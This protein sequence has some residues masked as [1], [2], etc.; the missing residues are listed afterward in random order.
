M[1]PYYVESCF[2][3]AL[4]FT[5]KLYF[6]I[7]FDSSLIK[8]YNIRAIENLKSD[9][10][11]LDVYFN[12]IN[13]THPGFDQ[14]LKHIKSIVSIFFTKRL[15]ILYETNIFKDIR[16]EDVIKFLMRFKNVKKSSQ[17]KGFITENDVGNMIKK[18]KESLGK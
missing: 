3:D 5:S 10:E 12:E 13:L 7:L 1:S 2:K 18:L 11:A 4:N 8:N 14:C 9:I 15:D 16:I 17:A 6:E